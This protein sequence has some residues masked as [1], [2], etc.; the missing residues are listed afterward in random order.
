MW[1]ICDLTLER[2]ISDTKK[3]SEEKERIC[4]FRR[5]ARRKKE[6]GRERGKRSEYNGRTE[7]QN[8]L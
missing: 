2:Q 5:K 4:F 1:S 3:T 6:K 7:T 8:E